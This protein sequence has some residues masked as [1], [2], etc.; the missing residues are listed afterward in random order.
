MSVSKNCCR[1]F[2]EKEV[3]I[4]FDPLAYYA[5]PGLMTAAGKYGA[6]FDPLPQDIS[7]LCRVV[8]GIMLHIF[9]AEQYGERLSEQRQSEVQVRPVVDKLARIVELDQR[10][11]TE[12]RPPE[13]RLVGNCRDFSVML[14]AMLRHQGVPARA[15]CGFGRYFIPDHYEDHWVCEYWEHRQKRWVLV[16]AQLDELQCRKLAI[17][18]N[19]LDVPRDQFLVGGKAWQL[20]RTGQADA[21]QFGIFD[22]KGLWFVRGDFVRDVAALNKVELLPWDGWGMIE[23]RDEEVSED[24]L[25]LLDRIAA[26]TG[27]DVPEVDQVRGLYENDDRL[28]VPRRIRSYTQHGVQEIELVGL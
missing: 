26:L 13:K 22:M 20:C 5:Q 21:D 9:W 19:P 6:L 12:I 18:F 10:P 16:D 1:P 15:R 28:R 23:K 24:E 3:E 2:N 25:A 11:L 27:E 7:A 17:S 4:V 8:Q 14:T